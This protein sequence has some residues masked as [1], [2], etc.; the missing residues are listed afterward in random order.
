MSFDDE[1][2][3]S[4]EPIERAPYGTK[5]KTKW[6]KTGEKQWTAVDPETGIDP[7]TGEVP[8]V[9][10]PPPPEMRSLSRRRAKKTKPK[11]HPKF[12]L[13]SSIIT[14]D[15]PGDPNAE[16]WGERE[17]YAAYQWAREQYF[18]GT[19]TLDQIA[20]HT[21]FDRRR[22]DAWA[23]QSTEKRMCWSKEREVAQNKA[24]REIARTTKETC[25]QIIKDTLKVVDIKV[26]SIDE[27]S[28]K[29]LSV[30]EVQCLVGVIG[31]LHKISQL[32][33]GKPT[34]ITAKV[35][36]TRQSV[37]DKL[38]AADPMVNYEADEPAKSE[39]SH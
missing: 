28:A 17:P 1:D 7:L 10:M 13:K 30:R 21:G 4:P 29:K 39:T 2:E 12:Q 35:T 5:N 8:K 31:D 32:E 23:F 6:V 24:I 18:Q 26:S 34:D 33:D 25:V 9:W 38:K 27:A 36:L 37:L 14:F 22:V 11:I 15:T 3:E 19:A 16:T 20:E